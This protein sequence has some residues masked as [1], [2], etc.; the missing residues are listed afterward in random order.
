MG[1]AAVVTVPAVVAEVAEP[2]VK[3]AAVP[4]S[5]VPAPKYVLAVMLPL[6]LILTRFTLPV[7]F[8]V[9]TMLALAALV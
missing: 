4:V 8:G 6:A 5:P 7:P 3:L 9:N 1:C 2:T